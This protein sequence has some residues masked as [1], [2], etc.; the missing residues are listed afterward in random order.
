MRRLYRFISLISLMLCGLA[1][2][3]W[4]RSYRNTFEVSVTTPRTTD[5]TVVTIIWDNQQ[6]IVRESYCAVEVL[7]G[8]LYWRWD[9]VEARPPSNFFHPSPESDTQ[10]LLVRSGI[11][12]PFGTTVSEVERTIVTGGGR[13]RFGF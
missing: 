10:G 2:G 5:G 12:A 11:R 1:V 6:E 7:P 3:L 8:R 13:I 9:V 4:V